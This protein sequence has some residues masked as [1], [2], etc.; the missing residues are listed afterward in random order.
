MLELA[1]SAPGE[2]ARL[3]TLCQPH[4]GVITRVGDAHLG[5]FGSLDAVADAK[6][7]LLR[8][9]RPDGWAVLA[10]TTS[11]CAAWRRAGRKSC[12]LAA[13]STTTSWPRTSKAVTGD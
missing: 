5:G 8:S 13:R 6:A 3:A 10:A 9:F 7:E 2:I 1:A 12:G 11:D 4:V